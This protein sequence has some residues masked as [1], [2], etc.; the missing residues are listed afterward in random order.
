M[1]FP[2]I[3]GTLGFGC[4]RLPTIKREIDYEEL[5]KMVDYFIENGYNYF[6]TAH[7]YVQ[8]KSEGAIK[9]ALSER[10]DR[11][12]FVLANKLTEDYFSSESDI[13]ALFFE[14]LN[15][16]GVDYFDFYM[17]HA[18]TKDYYKKYTQCNAFDIIKKLHNQGYIRHIGMSFHDSHDVLDKILAEH[19]EIE[20]VQ[21][22]FNYVDYDNP[23]I[24]SI[25]NYKVIRNHKRSI[26]VMEPIKGGGLLKLPDEARS[27]FVNGDK[28]ELAA[29]ALRYVASF[30]DIE[31]ILSGPSD[32]DMVINNVKCFN[33]LLPFSEEEHAIASNIRTIINKKAPIQCTACHY[34]VDVCPMKLQIPELISA[35]NSKVYFKGWNS[36]LYYNSLTT[37]SGKAS[38]CIKCRSC[39]KKCPQHLKISN[40]MSNIANSFEKKKQK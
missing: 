39:E 16:C 34:C 6:D 28:N 35:Y 12:A 37:K 32:C 29:F 40:I 3:K 18:I 8:G 2:E 9:K 17:F 25:E 21:I 19:P 5:Y 23:A 13:E 11:N 24:Q 4:M 1:K 22:Q 10:Y 14:Q 36:I 15:A 30:P 20:V 31:V 26:F 27:F 38:D 33:N 7:G